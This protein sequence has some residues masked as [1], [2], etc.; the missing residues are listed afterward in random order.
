MNRHVGDI[1][2]LILKSSEL[3]GEVRDKQ[4]WSYQ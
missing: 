3:A 2:R 4:V 1:D